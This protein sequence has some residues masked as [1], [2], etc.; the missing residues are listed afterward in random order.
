MQR[1][2]KK[3]VRHI[4]VSD[5]EDYLYKLKK[6]F[7]SCVALTLTDLYDSGVTTVTVSILGSDVIK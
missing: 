4:S 3:K 1:S 6:N 2:I 5:S 7:H